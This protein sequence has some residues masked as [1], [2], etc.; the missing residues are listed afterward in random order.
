MY[1]T[2]VASTNMGENDFMDLLWWINLTFDRHQWKML[3]LETAI[4]KNREENNM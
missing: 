1:A 3:T 2:Y 4:E